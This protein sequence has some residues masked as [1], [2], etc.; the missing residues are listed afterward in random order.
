MQTGLH[1]LRLPFFSD[2]H[3]R[4]ACGNRSSGNHLTFTTT[5]RY[6]SRSCEAFHRNPQNHG[7]TN[8]LQTAAPG[9]QKRYGHTNPREWHFAPLHPQ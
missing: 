3:S 8:G 5:R 1:D 2:L 6:L 9:N 7:Y 4:P